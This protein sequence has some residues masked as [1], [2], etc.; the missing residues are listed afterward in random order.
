MS[1]WLAASAIA[2]LM[3]SAAVAGAARRRP[4]GRG[5]PRTAPH[6]EALSDRVMPS[7]FVLPV[8]DVGGPVACCRADLEVP[9]APQPPAP[10]T[11]QDSPPAPA[12]C[13][14]YGATIRTER[15]EI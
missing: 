5:G 2:A 14:A 4:P 12:P 10:R 8:P 9:P 1:S 13:P 11:E 6:L 7:T 3:L 15:M